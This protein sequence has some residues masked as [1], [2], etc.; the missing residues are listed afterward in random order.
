MSSNTARAYPVQL[1]TEP[2]NLALANALRH[3]GRLYLSETFSSRTGHNRY[4]AIVIAEPMGVITDVTR[5]LAEATKQF[6]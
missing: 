4:Y 3:H 6:E 2:K 5:D 1:T